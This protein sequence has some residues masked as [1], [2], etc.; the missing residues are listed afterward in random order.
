[1]DVV[2]TSRPS[3]QC[4][5]RCGIC[6]MKETGEPFKESRLN[7]LIVLQLIKEEI[8]LRLRSCGKLC[9]L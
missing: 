7:F 8:G 4:I 2:A 3:M 1:M 6:G 5:T 9:V